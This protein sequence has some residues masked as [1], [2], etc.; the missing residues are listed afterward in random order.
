MG[1][2]HALPPTADEFNCGEREG[3]AGV[4]FS[5]TVSQ[6]PLNPSQQWQT[7]KASGGPMRGHSATVNAENQHTLNSHVETGSLQTQ[8]WLEVCKKFTSTFIMSQQNCSDKYTLDCIDVTGQFTHYI[9][10]NQFCRLSVR[11]TSIRL[12]SRNI[13]KLYKFKQFLTQ[14]PASFE[15]ESYIQYIKT[16]DS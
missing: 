9:Q 10:P 4:P 11:K 8:D 7:N 3:V 2:S 16:A 6:G 5:L 14:Y 15:Q 12:S 13:W 1:S